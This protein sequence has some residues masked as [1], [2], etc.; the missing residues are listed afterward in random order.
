MPTLTHARKL[1]KIKLWHE[2]MSQGPI[3]D[4]KKCHKMLNLY[5]VHFVTFF[6]VTRVN[7]REAQFS[8]LILSSDFQEKK[9]IKNDLERLFA[10]IRIFKIWPSESHKKYEKVSRII[11]SLGILLLNGAEKIAASCRQHYVNDLLEAF[12]RDCVLRIGSVDKHS[13][14]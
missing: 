4:S 13:K 10:W 6:N 1:A 9:N 14:P 12:L 8:P 2:K 3:F 7:A 5:S 11:S